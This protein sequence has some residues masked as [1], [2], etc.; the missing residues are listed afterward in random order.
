MLKRL[1]FKNWRSL[2]D[3]EIDNLT[4]ITV[5]IGANSSGKTNILDALHFL[6]YAAQKGT[7][8]AIFAWRGRD[9]IRTFGVY[10]H[11]EISYEVLL[12]EQ[13]KVKMF[14]LFTAAG[15]I[16]IKDEDQKV[17]SIGVDSWI[18]TVDSLL[19]QLAAERWQLLRENFLPPIALAT[20]T[21]PGDFYMIDP[22][23]RNAPTMLNFMQQLY[24][25]VY[26]VLQEDLRSLLTHV[27]S[28]ETERNDYETSFSITE[29]PLKGQEAPSI[30]GGTA[31]VI[32]MLLAYYALDMR[33][34]EQ[35]GLV[36][37]EEPDTAIHPLLLSNFV[38]LL[39]SYTYR[40]EPRQF[41]LTTHNP[42]LLNYFEPEEVRVVERDP[43]TGET[44]VDT[45]PTHLRETWLHRH[46]LGDAWTSRIIGGI[47]EE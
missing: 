45:L 46:R 42:E 36:V 21:D 4:P 2:R 34:H 18:E 37:I 23:A 6:R 30:S 3:V 35:P 38:D 33:T 47:P 24:P 26:N 9:K 43:D 27:S 20:D 39:R 19:D 17:H 40:K 44:Y 16:S 14:D 13:T 25:S 1:R 10:D 28:V 5:F 31:R 12:N 22:M 29:K 15:N 8:E 7:G 11:V 41:I 32:A